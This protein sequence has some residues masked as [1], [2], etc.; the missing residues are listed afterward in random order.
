MVVRPDSTP[1]GGL[2]LLWL[3][4]VQRSL[5]WVHLATALPGARSH[6]RAGDRTFPSERV[7][8]VVIRGDKKVAMAAHDHALPPSAAAAGLA[9]PSVIDEAENG[10]G[11][12]SRTS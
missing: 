12:S 4:D 9:K 3:P 5:N 1:G 11:I 10:F 7:S 2:C 8:V 6:Q